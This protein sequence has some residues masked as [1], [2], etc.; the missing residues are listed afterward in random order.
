MVSCSSCGEAN[1]P[2]LSYCGNPDCGAALAIA[3]APKETA[4]EQPVSAVRSGGRL[5]LPIVTVAAL[6]AVA[7]VVWIAGSGSGKDPARQEQAAKNPKW[8]Y[9]VVSSPS[10]S[11]TPDAIPS[12]TEAVTTPPATGGGGG[13]PGPKPTTPKP[14]P[15]TAG[16]PPPPA[17]A[18]SASGTPDCPPNNGLSDPAWGLRVTGSVSNTSSSIS[19]VTVYHDAV[20]SF[21]PSG[22]VS[23]SGSGSSFGP[24]FAPTFDGDPFLSVPPGA[25]SVRWK[26]VVR[27]ANGTTLDSGYRT[28][29]YNC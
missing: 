21:T 24:I 7:A 14:V 27:L 16:P 22:S 9:E 20:G 26:V 4:P 15:T 17:P 25:S 18:L 2:G 5:V 3:L 10:T 13:A 8:T 28:T 29:H 1:E 19:S 6:V 12:P 23:G 11:P